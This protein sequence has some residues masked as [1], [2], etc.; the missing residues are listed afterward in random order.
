M[1]GAEAPLEVSEKGSVSTS[2]SS[3]SGWKARRRRGGVRRG[4][5]LNRD[6]APWTGHVFD[7]GRPLVIMSL[8]QQ[9]DPGLSVPGCG[10]MGGGRG[11]SSCGLHV[12][13]FKK[14]NADRKG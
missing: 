3:C 4:F 11:K 13:L 2:E 8:S 6:C 14:A 5:F 9:I 10:R 12:Q 1:M 7:W